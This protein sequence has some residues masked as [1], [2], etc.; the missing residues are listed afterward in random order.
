MENE[1]ENLLA[2]ENEY[3]KSLLEKHGI[4]YKLESDSGPSNNRILSTA[5]ISAEVLEQLRNELG[6]SQ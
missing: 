5:S 3:L 6:A 4:I 1:T 2:R